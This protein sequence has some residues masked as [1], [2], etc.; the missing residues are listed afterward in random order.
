MQKN[1]VLLLFFVLFFNNFS[2]FGQKYLMLDRYSTERIRISIGEQ[3]VFRVKNDPFKKTDVIIGLQDSV[4]SLAKYGEISLAEF[5]IFYLVR[6][7][8]KLKGASKVFKTLG[9]FFGAFALS[10]AFRNSKERN[11]EY[12]TRQIAYSASA[13][14][15]SALCQVLHKRTY[16]ITP[17]TR[18]RIMNMDTPNQN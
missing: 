17:Q 12:M 9:I 15:A 18:I 11:N 6:A 14:A 4:V 16:H 13:F 10:E 3:V 2:L 8:G 7:K 5:D 1:I